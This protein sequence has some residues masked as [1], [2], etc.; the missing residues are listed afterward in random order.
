MELVHGPPGRHGI[1]CR[2]P[3]VAEDG[4]VAAHGE[5][6]SHHAVSGTGIMTVGDQHIAAQT[7]FEHANCVHQMVAGSIGVLGEEGGL[8]AQVLRHQV[9][10][11]IFFSRGGREVAVAYQSVHIISFQSRIRN[12]IDA[13]LQ[14]KAEARPP[15]NNALGSVADADNGELV[16]QTHR[17]TLLW[18]AA[19]DTGYF[20]INDL[21]NK[22]V[23]EKT[24][25]Y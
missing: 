10:C 11:D 7:R 4:V 21:K 18:F 5:E 12:G 13:G 6:Q 3:E 17:W 20:I 14:V 25:S 8:E 22:P 23:G 16:F 2:G 9:R 19:T 1:F 15:R 24:K